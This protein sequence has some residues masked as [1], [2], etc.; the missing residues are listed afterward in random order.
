MTS[1][2]INISF[3]SMLLAFLVNKNFFSTSESQWD[4]IKKEKEWS[5]KVNGLKKSEH[6]ALPPMKLRE[7]F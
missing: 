6:S 3:F 2:Q 7:T 1:K 5:N 4:F